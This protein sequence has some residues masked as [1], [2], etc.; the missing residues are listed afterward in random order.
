MYVTLFSFAI[1]KCIAPVQFP[2]YSSIAHIA[3]L[4]IPS[5]LMIKKKFWC[6]FIYY[7]A[8][9]GYCFRNVDPFCLKTKQMTLIHK[10]R[11]LGILG[12]VITSVWLPK[13]ATSLYRERTVN[14]GTQIPQSL[15]FLHSFTLLRFYSPN[16]FWLVFFPN[17]F[18]SQLVRFYPI[19]IKK[20]E[21]KTQTRH[22]S[23]KINSK[24]RK[25]DYDLKLFFFSVMHIAVFLYWKIC[26][27]TNWRPS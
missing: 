18:S 4:S 6:F 24:E 5:C 23:K 25:S 17:Y 16:Q 8:F 1:L 2:Y 3:F 27:F 13:L 10:K 21:N 19:L 15:Y 14:K 11:R 7:Y 9:S 20:K 22:I 12:L 26:N